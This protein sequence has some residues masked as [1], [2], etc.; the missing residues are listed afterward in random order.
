MEIRTGLTVFHLK[1]ADNS[2]DWKIQYE[3]K[4]VEDG[5]SLLEISLDSSED[6]TPPELTLTWDLPLLDTVNGWTTRHGGG[7]ELPPDWGCKRIFSIADEIPELVFH[8]REGLCTAA[9][10]WSDAMR[11]TEFSGGIHE[12]DCSLRF[13]LKLFSRKEAPLRHYCG[14]L[15]L[16]LR[17][18]FFADTVR[19]I[20]SWYASFPEYGNSPVPESA[21]DPLYST[22]Y[23]YHHDV[24][25]ESI[26]RECRE[27]VKLGMKT[28][29]VDSGWDNDD[30][31]LGP[32]ACGEWTP[33]KKRFPDFAS[34]VREIQ[35]L[36][37]RYM[38]WFAVPFI[39][40]RSVRYAQFQGKFLF[41]LPDAGVL[42]P[43]FPDVREF[44]IG[45][46]T[47]LLRQYGID[48][49]KLDFINTFTECTDDPALSGGMGTRDIP[50]I[51][52]AVDR[53]MTDLSTAL[54]SIRP[55]AL[56]EFRQ[57]YIG[58]AIR[59][60]GNLLRA[61]DC[62]ADPGGNRRRILNL[63][64]SSGCTAVHSDMLEWRSDYDVHHAA[65]QLLSVM[66][67]VPQI[68][69]RLAELPP[70]HR[71]MLAFLLGFFV[72]HRELLLKSA[73]HPCAP[74]HNYPVVYAETERERIATVY[75]GT[76]TVEM[77]SDPAGR[78]LYL[79]NAT[80]RDSIVADLPLEP[81]TTALLRDCCG[82]IL[83]FELPS[84]GLSRLRMPPGSILKL[85]PPDPCE[86]EKGVRR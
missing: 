32:G 38:L 64:L 13:T 40:K 50:V 70:E 60:Y 71:Q 52:D 61:A 34:H 43:R 72:R 66:F 55:D 83:P 74:D 48:G 42:D 45:S 6:R 37:L 3:W 53:L 19:E 58:P 78:T 7:S 63:R 17:K 18:Q 31:T 62:P 84:G 21:F 86:S 29:I 80:A 30:N 4:E 24:H 57:C 35:A 22:W 16:D 67:A 39:G 47:R 15:R 85:N 59:K 14:I 46:C 10:A 68:S 41:E 81:G 25:A 23:S 26:L 69:V 79:V 77:D 9:A 11:I 8:N 56:I 51:T 44:L 36:G 20:S 65:L 76:S 75:C 82:K 33:S 27:A 1:G 2:P 12:S 5:L 54:R 28:L 49:L 73:L